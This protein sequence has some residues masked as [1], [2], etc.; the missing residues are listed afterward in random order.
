M[1][2]VLGRFAGS[3]ILV[4]GD[5]MVDEYIKGTV[6]RISPE[7]PVPV[8]LEREVR[9]VPGGAGNVVR[10]LRSLGARVSLAGVVGE[11][12]AAGIL[13]GDF[14]RLGLSPQ[15]RAGLISVSGR[16][17]TRKTRIMAGQQQI[18]RLDRESETRLSDAVRGRILAAIETTI[19]AAVPRV[20]A[21]ILSDYDKG[22]IQPDVIQKTVEVAR[23]HDCFIAVDPQVTHFQDYK[24][25]GVLTP[26]HHEAGRYLKRK[27]VD[28]EAVREGGLEILESLRAKMLLITRG[29][30]G[31]TLFQAGQKI[32]ENFPTMAREVFDVTGAGDTVISVFTL[33]IAAGASAEDAVRLSNLAAGLVVA[34]L[35]AATVTVAELGAA[36]D[37]ART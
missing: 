26:N 3:H 6:E 37:L 31:I 36:V 24:D 10:N 13:R 20:Q 8:V 16:P 18:V 23:R 11:D 33:A 27:L 30:K 28:D 4:V 12:E 5:F 1:K 7:A 19:E 2:D 35:G 29:E 25:V 22:V 34:H 14:E 21:V 15:D 9:T 32:A 17:T